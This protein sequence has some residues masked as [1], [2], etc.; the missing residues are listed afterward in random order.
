LDAIIT[1]LLALYGSILLKISLNLHP[2]AWFRKLTNIDRFTLFLTIFTALL[3]LATCI[4]VLA[5]IRSE[6]AF[7]IVVGE[8]YFTH[9]RPSAESGGWDL[10]L[11]IK[12][13]GKHVAVITELNITPY[14]YLHQNLPDIP[15][16]LPQPE[17]R[18]IPPIAP[19]SET[20][21]IANVAEFKAT[22]PSKEGVPPISPT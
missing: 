14:S 21:F 11:T 18:V 3:A 4:Q 6:E 7:L 5:F 10:G 1:F 12:N 20:S 19:E 13:V 22:V 17:T 2:V 9:G 15:K 16:Y 8:P